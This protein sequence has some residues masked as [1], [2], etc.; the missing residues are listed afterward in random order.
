MKGYTTLKEKDLR[1]YRTRKNILSAMTRLLQT[2]AFEQ[3]T[4]TNICEE[5]EISRSGFYLHYVDKYD[6]V[7]VNLKEFRDQA[8]QFIFSNAD[9]SKT[10]LFSNMLAYL[11]SDGKLIAALISENGSVEVQN[12]I[13][14]MMQ[15]N[16]RINIFPK[17]DLKIKNEIEEHYALLFLSNALFGV[18]QDW[19]NRGQKESP[20]E[21]VRIMDRLITFDF[22]K[23]EKL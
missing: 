4:V 8:N 15:E 11:Q 18:L 7:E 3:I 14:R 13:K 1:Y 6:L 21:L 20:E 9:T 22:K 10:A 23:S 2:K 16:A 5:A 17:L 19:I 12:Y